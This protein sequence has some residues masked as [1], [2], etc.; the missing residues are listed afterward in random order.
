M[1]AWNLLQGG[2]AEQR[3]D[4]ICCMLHERLHNKGE[5]G[6]SVTTSG[7]RG[8]GSLLDTEGVRVSPIGIADSMLTPCECQCMVCGVVSRQHDVRV[9]RADVIVQ[10]AF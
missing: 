3:D 10:H 5:R 6:E 8:H 7:H 4:K 2:D 1:Y 9:S